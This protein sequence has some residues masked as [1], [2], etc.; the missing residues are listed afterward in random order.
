MRVI[1]TFTVFFLI[2]AFSAFAQNPTWVSKAK[3]GSD[4]A[5]TSQKKD[6]EGA[7]NVLTNWSKGWMEFEASTTADMAD[8]TNPGQAEYLAKTAARML[9]YRKAVEFLNGV[10]IT[11]ALTGIDK[12]VAKVDVMTVKT[13]GMVK[14][15]PVVSENF[16]WKQGPD[17]STYPWGTVK[18]GILLYG[19]RPDNNILSLIYDE[20]K[21]ALELSGYQTYEPDPII[22]EEKTPPEPYTGLILDAKGKA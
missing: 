21:S 1:T 8:A 19:D 22:I 12:G 4:V 14:N 17:G 15:A 10:V 3:E 13:S 6:S 20:T 16:E 7:Y 11:D 18:V 2:V 9:A 5:Y